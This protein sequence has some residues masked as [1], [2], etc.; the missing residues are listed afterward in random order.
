MDVD[1][2]LNKIQTCLLY[3]HL[4]LNKLFASLYLGIL[5]DR[6]GCWPET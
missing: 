4:V 5:S 1:G 6:H 3:Y 2:K